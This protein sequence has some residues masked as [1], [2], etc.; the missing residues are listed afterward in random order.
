MSNYK[1]ISKPIPRIEGKALAMGAPFF[2]DD[3][4]PKDCLTIKL[5]HS[6]YASAEVEA[7]DISIASKV[8]G[9]V[10]IFTYEDTTIRCTSG[11]NY[12]PYEHTLLKRV[13]RYEGD[14]VAMVVAET[15]TAAEIARNLIKIKWKIKKPL[16]D[17]EKSYE[18]EIVVHQDQLK[19]IVRH[20]DGKNINWAEAYIPEKNKIK[21]AIYEFGPTDEILEKSDVVVKVKSNTPQQMHV[22]LETHRCYCYIDERENLVING[23]MQAIYGI[24]DTVA[25]ML[26][27]DKRKIRTVKAQ[28]GGGFGSKNVFNAYMFPAFATY[29]LR[30]PTKLIMS[31]EE[32]MTCTGTRHEYALTITLGA[33][34][35]GVIHALDSTGYMNGGA[36]CELTDEVL[37]TGIFNTYPI[38]PRIDAVRINQ[39]AVHTNKVMG[40]AFRGFGA[41]QNTF[42]INCAVRH[43]ADKLNMDIT[44]VC[45]KNIARLGDSHPLMN[46]YLPEDPAVITSIALKECIERAMELIDW[47]NKHNSVPPKGNIVRGVGIGI[48]AHASGIPRDDRAAVNMTLNPDGSFSVF[49]GH[50]D[51]GTGSNTT[52]LQIVAET[53]DV[54]MD[55]IRLKAADS[56]FTPFDNGT[57]ASSN[58]FRAGG[59]AKLAADKMLSMLLQNAKEYLK[60]DQ[61]EELSFSN[62]MFYDKN[63]KPILSLAEFAG[64]MISYWNGK[65]QLVASASFPVHFAPSP[66]VATCIEVEIDK[67]TGYYTLEK[68]VTVVDSGQ[69]INPNNARVQIHGGIV[70][71]LGMAMFEEVKYNSDDKIISKDMQAYKIPC[72]MDIPH[73][74]VEFVDDYEPSGPFGA[75]SLGEIATSS[76]AP[77]LCDAIFNAT[78]IHF[79]SLPITPEKLLRGHKGKEEAQI[80]KM[81]IK[82][83]KKAASLKEAYDL[84]NLAKSNKII[85]GC[86]FLKNIKR[87][88]NIAIDLSA[89]GLSY[90]NETETD[91]HIG[92]YTCLR[93]IETSPVIA[94]EFGNSLNDVLQHLIGIQ[95][96]NQITI[97]AHVYSRFGFSDIIPTLLA[98]N[99][100]VNLFHGGIMT[101]KEFLEAD[102]NKDILVEV[103]LP[104]EHRKTKVQMMRNSFNDYSIFCLAVSRNEK[105]E[106]IIAAGVRPGRAVLAVSSAEKLNKIGISSLDIE[107]MA[108]EIVEEF[109]FGTNYRGT[110]SYRKDLCRTFAQRALR[111]LS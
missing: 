27:I 54:P 23:P 17:F 76:P 83:Y 77:A 78:G 59:A 36:Y 25:L 53:L 30:R 20:Q 26:G 109:T 74:V 86:T 7:M 21:S 18:N 35:T 88:I 41:T 56:A 39:T 100:N 85:G 24:Q 51:I 8:P 80:F 65:E 34:K 31:R 98:L 102:I 3:F 58:V 62:E 40:C 29:V 99:A 82:E 103:I 13:A 67:E 10:K 75:K 73:L 63:H 72:Q 110:A 22:V 12:S 1:Y 5:V 81:N 4:I 32:S 33:D 92:A 94:K 11:Y 57:Y 90:I 89:C 95:L 61:E 15:D 43:L 19:D 6:P 107:K 104:K 44:E 55:I 2:V 105:N 48:G 14:I 52:M 9:V 60:M 16:M 49:T 101:L 42:A 68:V 97:G 84:L 79:D 47:K 87:Q 106:W 70:Q 46:G 71:S 111:E 69:I 38:F 50:S 45:L 108:D 66:Y 96:R 64:K 28:V 37:H 93:E 91:V